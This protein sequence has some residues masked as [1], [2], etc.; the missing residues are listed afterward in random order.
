MGKASGIFLTVAGT[1]CAAHV[2]LLETATDDQLT[3]HVQRSR[4]GGDLGLWTAPEAWRAYVRSATAESAPAVVTITHRPYEAIPSSVTP[5]NRASLGIELQRELKRVG[6]YDGHLNGS[7]TFATRKAMKAFMN[8]VNAALPIDQPD[9]ILLALLQGHRDKACGIAC[10]TGQGLTSDDRCLPNA[11]LAQTTKMQHSTKSPATSR[12]AAPVG[13]TTVAT[14]SDTQNPPEDGRMML[15]GPPA[16]AP[17][18]PAQGAPA[19]A[20]VAQQR[21]SHQRIRFGPEILR[22]AFG[23]SRF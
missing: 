2:M 1:V 3:S 8:R 11:I 18:V 10:P 13:S 20:V 7:W 6:C 12:L 19:R 17:A 4:G 14:P 16:A 15:S 21:E 9:H 5:G 23:L 22:E